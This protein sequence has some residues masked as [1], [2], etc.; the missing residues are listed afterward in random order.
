MIAVEVAIES[1][2]LSLQAHVARPEVSSSDPS[3]WPGL[4]L[5]HG[6]PADPGGAAAAGQSYPELAERLAAEAGWVVLTFHFRGAGQSE[7]N[8]SM[9]GW[10]ADLRRATDYLLELPEVSGAWLAGFSTGGALALCAAAEDERVRGVAALAAPA[11]FGQWAADPHAFL[12]RARSVG[13]VRA[14]A[15]PESFEDW[16]RQLSE[17]RAVAAVGKIPPR[18]LLLVHG[19]DDD[20]VPLMD[21]RA[22]A[23]AAGGQVELRL[24]TGA[25]HRLRH[26]PRA[27]AVLLGW[28]VTQASTS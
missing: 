21:A 27:V 10:L 2:G 18:P 23:D 28:L 1:D 19:S 3:G 7:G 25:G 14:T 12:E 5:C 20:V 17:V 6:F 24:I 13:V 11:D 8:F 22:L 16:S 9:A 26:D 4:V 15:F